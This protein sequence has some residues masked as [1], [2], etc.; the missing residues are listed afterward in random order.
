MELCPWSCLRR[1]SNASKPLNSIIIIKSC[2]YSKCNK[3]KKSQPNSIITLEFG[4][5]NFTVKN[6][7]MK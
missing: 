5:N 6:S 2:Q 7:L 1:V 4:I 3:E